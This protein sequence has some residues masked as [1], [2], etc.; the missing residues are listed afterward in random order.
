M[1]LFDK[2]ELKDINQG[3][4]VVRTTPGAVLV[5]VRSK[6]EYQR[7]HISGAV[8]IPQ[9]RMDLAAN[10]LRDK[11]ALIYVYGSYEHKPGKSVKE[12]KKLGYT[13]VHS[14]GSWE[15]H[16]VAP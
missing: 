1:R 5:D 4:N 13:D 7:G 15:E 12:F 10:R 2:K 14:C 3:I 6:E 11:N 16:H 9:N 8:N